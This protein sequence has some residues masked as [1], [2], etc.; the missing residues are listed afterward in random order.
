MRVLVT[1]ASGFVGRA[2]TAALAGPDMPVR[3]AAR[4]PAEVPSAAHVEPVYLPD[5]TSEIDWQPLLRDVDAVVHLAGIAHAGPGIDESLYDRVNRA[6]TETLAAACAGK[7]IHLVFVS[8]IRAQTGPVAGHI[9]TEADTPNPTDAY[10]RSKLAAE[11]AVRQSGAAFTI[12][13]PVVMYGPGVKGNV[14]TLL[15]LANT[16]LPLPLA[17]LDK[18]RSL[19][20]VDNLIEAVRHA[21]A[22][23]ATRGETCIVADDDPISLAEMIAILRV[24]QGRKPRL[25]SLPPSFFSTPLTLAGRRDVWDRIGGSLVVTAAKL[26]GT[27]WQPLVNTREGLR[28]T[29][30]AASPRKSGTASRN[31]P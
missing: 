5:L 15:R 2:L 6:A 26:R 8:S 13:R 31:T 25:F 23:P 16:P 24:A 22:Q 29:A 4:Q 14:A 28:A 12:L 18:Q 3:A 27:G 11:E 21:L 19:L 9:L 20:A 1:G 30:Q 10:G 17:S 7:S